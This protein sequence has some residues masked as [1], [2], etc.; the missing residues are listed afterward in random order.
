MRREGDQPKIV[1]SGGALESETT[2]TTTTTSHRDRLPN[3]HVDKL[4][5][6]DCDGV[7]IDSD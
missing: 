7:K 3:M 6:K 1:E 4:S 2:T 5:L